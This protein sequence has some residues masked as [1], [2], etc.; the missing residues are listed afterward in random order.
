[1]NKTRNSILSGRSIICF[2][3]MIFSVYIIFFLS[4]QSGQASVELSDWFAGLLN[5]DDITG[6]KH[7]STIPLLWGLNLRAY[8]HIVLYAILGCAVFLTLGHV[9][10]KQSQRVIFTLG[11]CLI[12][13]CV[14]ELHQLHIPERSAQLEDIVFDAVGYL[15]AVLICGLMCMVREL[16]FGL[17]R[18]REEYNSRIPLE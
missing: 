6:V 10:I 14:D 7:I 12:F 15:S 13:S 9:R 4:N 8:G 11:V 18:A 2:G 3:M 1:M 17:S 5:M 16:F